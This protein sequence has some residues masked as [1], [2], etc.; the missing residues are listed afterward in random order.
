MSRAGVASSGPHGCGDPGADPGA[1]LDSDGRTGVPGDG[2]VVGSGS[3]PAVRGGRVFLVVGALVL[4]VGERGHQPRLAHRLGS[5]TCGRCPCLRNGNGGGLLT[6][7]RLRSCGRLLYRGG[8][9]AGCVR[10]QSDV[11]DV[12][13][14]GVGAHRQCEVDR[15]ARNGDVGQVGVHRPC[16]ARCFRYGGAARDHGH[17]RP[18]LLPQHVPQHIQGFLGCRAGIQVR[19]DDQRP[20]PAHLRHRRIRRPGVP[21]A[22]VSGPVQGLLLLRVMGL[23]D[24]YRVG[25]VRIRSDPVAVQHRQSGS[26]VLSGD[27]D[28]ELLGER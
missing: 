3:G 21:V 23:Q 28:V 10:G 25:Q 6:P 4:Q 9:V 26:G 17:R 2:D 15:G 8:D 14:F 5:L 16:C 13:V 18:R 12:R 19:D 24:L 20:Q 7:H 1:G 27:R 11:Q 22:S